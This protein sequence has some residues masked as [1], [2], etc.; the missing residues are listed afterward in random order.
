M[1]SKWL[2]D[3]VKSD[4]FN[5]INFTISD[6][7]DDEESDVLDTTVPMLDKTIRGSESEFD[8][9]KQN[10]KQQSNPKSILSCIWQELAFNRGQNVTVFTL[11]CAL[12][13][14]FTHS[15]GTY[16]STQMNSLQ[17]QFGFSSTQTGFITSCND[18]GFFLVVL[19]ANQVAQNFH[20]P[21][22]LTRVT[23]VFGIAICG[24]GMAY[25]FRPIVRIG[26]S[27]LL[28]PT[29]KMDILCVRDNVGTDR[30]AARELECQLLFQEKEKR[31]N[32]VFFIFIFCMIVQGMCKAPRSSFVPVFIDNNIAKKTRSGIYF[33]K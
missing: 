26:N 10:R 18:I 29:A 24:I 13:G 3:S 21:R 19:F 33:G 31:N 5:P 6:I 25:F 8:T 20:I 17:M 4:V 14:C 28:V 1:T 12:S 15:V 22:I 23:V 27:T 32:I 9:E 2:R 16:I 7:E 11:L 30:I